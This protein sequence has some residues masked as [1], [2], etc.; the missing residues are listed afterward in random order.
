MNQMYKI[1]IIGLGAGDINQLPLGIY[2]KLQRYERKVF[3][4]TM[5]HPVIEALQEEQITFKAFDY[6]YEEH[7]DFA[8]VYENI[9]AE[10]VEAAKTSPVLYT[11]P[12]HPMVAEQ[13][14]QLLLNHSKVEAEVL[15][16]ASYLDDLF[17]TLA[18]DP[19]DGFQFVDATQFDRGELSFDSHLV[20]CQVYNAFIASEVKLTLLEVLPADYQVWVVEAAGTEKEQKWK[21]P[22]EE[23]DRHLEMSN[24]MSVYIP[25]V[26]NDLLLH[27]FRQLREIVR[28]LRG[29]GGCP[30][31]QK[32]THDSLRRYL[33]EETYELLEA[34]TEEDDLAITEELGDVLLQVLLHSQIGE[35]SGY[36]SVDDVIQSLAKKMIHRHPHVFG[37]EEPYKSWEQLKAEE[38]GFSKKQSVL[39]GILAG[40]PGLH[41]AEALQKRAATVGFDWSH[42]AEVW[43]KYKEEQREF[44]EAIEKHDQ[45][46]MEEELGDL[47]FVLTNIAR[48]YN[49]D[50]EIAIVEANNKFIR[51]FK[52]IEQQVRGENK[53]MEDVSLEEMDSMWEIAKQKERE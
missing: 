51:R 34:I 38:K 37:G 52:S 16:G 15:G 24:L 43:E 45:S 40:A 48:H 17:T 50:A 12:G 23:L 49:I 42:V 35:E 30:W 39:D 9:V 6:I 53:S 20:F 10:L 11:V 5:D 21:L 47:L 36:F 32:Q 28:T 3:T 29:P 33:L 1:E 27:E 2:R 7:D 19:I 46:A 25:P 31:D 26:P 13:T 41:T 14:V 44:I 22:L 8:A 4:R 18:I